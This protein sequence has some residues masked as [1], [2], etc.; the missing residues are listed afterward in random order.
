MGRRPQHSLTNEKPGLSLFTRG[1]RPRPADFIHAAPGS[2]KHKEFHY[3]WEFDLRASP[4][5]LWPL[6]ADTNRFNRDAGVPALDGGGRA[7]TSAAGP[8]ARRRLRLSKLGVRVEWDEEPF[9]WVRPHR[10]GV[11]RRYRSG[12]VAEM[13][14]AAE[15]RARAGGGTHLVYEIWACPRGPLGRAAIPIQIGRLSARKFAQTFRRYDELA[16]R[17]EQAQAAAPPALGGSEP[18]A[19]HLKGFDD[20]SFE[21]WRVTRARP[22]EER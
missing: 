6:V 3:R 13:R 11:V 14:V 20:E 19:A 17:S 16:L 2:V 22:E 12:P 18:V 5:A 10:F 9:E 21:L 1:R 4:Q 15:L 8:N 7:E